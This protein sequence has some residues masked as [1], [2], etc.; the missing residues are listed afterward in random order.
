[1]NSETDLAVKMGGAT[2]CV[3]SAERMPDLSRT[4]V[5]TMSGKPNGLSC[6]EQAPKG[7]RSAHQQQSRAES[8]DTAAAQGRGWLVLFR[9]DS[10]PGAC[11]GKPHRAA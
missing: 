11:S 10:N 1:M 8:R 7:V 3:S 9:A 6:G 4:K 2:R 5:K